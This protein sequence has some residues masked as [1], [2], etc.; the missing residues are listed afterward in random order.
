MLMTLYMLKFTCEHGLL[1]LPVNGWRVTAVS[2]MPP[3]NSPWWYG[4]IVPVPDVTEAQV[5]VVE[6]ITED[7]NKQVVR[8]TLP[9]VGIEFPT[10]ESTEETVAWAIT[11]WTDGRGIGWGAWT[12][13]DA[14]A[15]PAT[16]QLS[17][18][19]VFGHCPLPIRS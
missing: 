3:T 13:A 7:L 2:E 18:E 14:P 9:T 10:V 12:P 17:V 1:S 11:E 6:S 8:V 5:S 4:E 19:I 15:Y 16:A